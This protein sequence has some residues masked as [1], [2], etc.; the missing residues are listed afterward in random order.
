M[1][2]IYWSFLLLALGFTFIVLEVFIPSAGLLGIM[3]GCF[4]V[5]GIVFAFME[6]YYTGSIVLLLTLLAVPVYMAL[7][8][9]IWPYTPIGKLVLLKDPREEND[10]PDNEHYQKMVELVGQVGVAKS[11]MILSGQIVVG[12][13]KYDAI[14]NGFP[15]EAG[16]AIK[17]VAVK[18]N[19]IYVEAYDGDAASS[20]DLPVRDRGVLSTPIEELGI[21]LSD[22]GLSTS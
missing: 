6:G 19:R 17:V 22:D 11:E 20:E 18:G 15:I 4:M 2:P 14:S 8:V 9:H 1:D 13:Q 3:A 16:T 7:M 10:D 5:A 12:D 21:D